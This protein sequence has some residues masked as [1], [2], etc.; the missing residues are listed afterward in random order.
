M[1]NTDMVRT[2]QRIKL[3]Q[4]AREQRLKKPKIG[5]KVHK[6]IELMVF[7][8][9]PLHE[10]AQQA[11]L[12]TFALRQAFNRPHVVAHLKARKQVHRETASSRN[13]TR[14]CEIRDAANN[15]PA[16]QAIKTLE[17]LGQDHA[18]RPQ[19]LSVS[20]GITILIQTLQA[21]ARETVTIDAEP[22]P[23]TILEPPNSDPA[24]KT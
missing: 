9:F 24:G 11:E 17:E 18:A 19:Q 12:T 10:A 16:V 15:M 14:L 2:E 3:P 5:K 20:P 23:A 4:Q 1:S 8:G 22:S 6:A 13:I 21:N 7:D